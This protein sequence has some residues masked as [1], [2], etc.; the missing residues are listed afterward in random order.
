MI[1][2]NI[3]NL[4]SNSKI[5]IWYPVLN[6]LE[7]DSFIQNIRKKGI[8][9]IIN[10]EVPIM[11]Y[12]DNVGMQGSGLLLINFLNRSIMKNLKEAIHE[13]KNILKQEENSTRFKLRYL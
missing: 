11:K 4:F 9:N 6:I 7:N 8:S 2:N 1:L 5:I 3:D 13:I 12:G 10:V